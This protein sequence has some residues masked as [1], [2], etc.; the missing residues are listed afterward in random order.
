MAQTFVYNR[1]GF[2]VQSINNLR[3]SPPSSGPTKSLLYWSESSSPL[4]I[5]GSP[6]LIASGVM[7]L[8]N[9]S[10]SSGGSGVVDLTNVQAWVDK[11]VISGSATVKLRP[12]PANSI[13]VGGRAGSALI[14]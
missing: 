1:G 6:V 11:V 10:L 13:K 4:A 7:F 2:D 12:D 8:G 3:W 14:R 5:Q 9:G